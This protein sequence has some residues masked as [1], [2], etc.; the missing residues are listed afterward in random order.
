[1]LNFKELRSPKLIISLILG[2]VLWLTVAGLGFW[3]ARAMEDPNNLEAFQNAIDSLGIWGWF[4]LIGIQFVQVVVIVIPS[5]PIQV[6]GGAL[7]GPLLAIAAFVIGTVLGCAAIFTLVRRFGHRVV[8]FFIG[9][10]DILKYEFLKD[11]KKLNLLVFVLYLI[12]GTK[13]VLTYL[14][15]LTPIRWTPFILISMAVRIPQTF[16]LVLAG[17]FIIHGEWIR[18]MGIIGFVAILIL[19]GIIIQRTWRHKRM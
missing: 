15:A 5:G 17:D 12:P 3:W 2:S 6:L 8:R 16:M 7:Y 11:S 14:F 13:D 9:E 1:M 18:L 19:I 10:R 4:A